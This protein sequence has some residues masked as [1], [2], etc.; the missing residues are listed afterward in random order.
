MALEPPEVQ[1]TS[2]RLQMSPDMGYK[3]GHFVNFMARGI[4]FICHVFSLH[5]IVSDTVHI[6][7]LL[8]S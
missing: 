2:K 4:F 7:Q 8:H 3:P 1:G 6:S 5:I